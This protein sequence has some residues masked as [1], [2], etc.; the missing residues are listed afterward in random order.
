MSQHNLAL[1]PY[2]HRV[3][4]TNSSEWGFLAG[5]KWGSGGQKR[6]ERFPPETELC[7]QQPGPPTLRHSC[8]FNLLYVLCDLLIISYPPCR[9]LPS[10]TAPYWP[11]LPLWPLA[12]PRP[13]RRRRG[14]GDLL[15]IIIWFSTLHRLVPLRQHEGEEKIDLFT[16]ERRHRFFV[17]QWSESAHIH[18]DKCM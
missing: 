5:S 12:A 7:G 9:P 6:G 13:I 17:M 2:F 11:F 8:L 14:G 18:R 1:S 3:G 15:Y 16:N 4:F 10:P